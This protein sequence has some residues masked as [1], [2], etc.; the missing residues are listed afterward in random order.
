MANLQDAFAEYNGPN[1]YEAGLNF[2]EGKFHQSFKIAHE[3]RG[4]NEATK[5]LQTER[6]QS[7]LPRHKNM[8]HNQEQ[9]YAGKTSS[10][11]TTKNY[12]NVE[13]LYTHR[14]CATDTEQMRFV[15]DVS[16]DILH[17]AKMRLL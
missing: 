14:T 6:P 15:L 5:Q 11:F 9:E 10:C 17:Q 2:I 1:E 4:K 7:N 8:V 12:K 13:H 3:L 16:L